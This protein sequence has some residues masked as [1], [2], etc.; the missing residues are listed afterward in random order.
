MPA[1]I[2][3]LIAAIS[4]TPDAPGTSNTPWREVTM[5]SFSVF[6][7]AITCERLYCV[8]QP[9]AICALAR[10]RSPSSSMTFLFIMVRATARL[11]ESVVLPTPPLP[12]AMPITSVLRFTVLACMS[13]SLYTVDQSMSGSDHGHFVFI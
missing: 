12:L 10:P 6:S 9:S 1:V 13:G 7:P 8:L 5:I 2:A 11:V 3:G 4:C